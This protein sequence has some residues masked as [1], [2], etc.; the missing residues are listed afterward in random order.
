MADGILAIFTTPKAIAKIDFTPLS[1]YALPQ[2]LPNIG[3]TCYLNSL[4][5]SLTGCNLFMDYVNKIWDVIL[6]YYSN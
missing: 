5:Q 4:L 3:N 6:I 2:G 1:S